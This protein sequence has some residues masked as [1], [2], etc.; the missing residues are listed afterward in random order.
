MPRFGAGQTIL[1]IDDDR[2]L[3]PSLVETIRAFSD[4]NVVTADNGVTALERFFETR[5]DCVMVDVRMPGLDGYQLVRMLRGDAQT[6]T[7][8]LIILTALAK[9]Q[10]R[11]VGLASGADQYLV[12]PVRP[13]ALMEAIRNAIESSQEERAQRL[14]GL[15]DSEPPQHDDAK[16]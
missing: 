16:D 13:R 6:A 8:P 4:F 15:A 14:L 3:L 7:I 10:N 9:E 1:V 12:K 5:P 2:D 11:F